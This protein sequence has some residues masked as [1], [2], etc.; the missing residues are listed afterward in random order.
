MRK[1]KALIVDDE[2]IGAVGLAD[3]LEREDW[4]VCPIASTGEKALE[5]AGKERPDIVLMDVSLHGGLSGVETAKLI[6]ERF[7]LPVI[8]MSGYSEDR[9][10]EL[11][12]EAGLKKGSFHFI[13]KPLYP[14]LVKE[15]LATVDA[16]EN[17][18][19][20][21]RKRRSGERASKS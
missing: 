5:I 14:E 8:F 13:G 15:A 10:R 9:V 16:K 17:R 2:Y 6:K 19:K 21:K 3:M 20:G 12:E 7:G 11:E 1:K 18:L 4:D